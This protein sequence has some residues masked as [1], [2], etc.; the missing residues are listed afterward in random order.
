[1]NRIRVSIAEYIRACIC[2]VGYRK[3]NSTLL[4]ILETGTDP[5]K[6]GA[7]SASTGRTCRTRKASTLRTNSPASEP[8]TSTR[9]VAEMTDVWARKRRLCLTEFV[10]NTD[11]NVRRSIIPQLKLDETAYPPELRTLVKE[12]IEIGRAHADEYIRHRTAV[13][14]GTEHLY[15]P[16]PPRG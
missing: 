13:Q 1:M 12:A 11:L 8:R 16:L 15:R 14:L 6:A 4:D 10:R 2:S 9:C 5:H 7:A 3:V